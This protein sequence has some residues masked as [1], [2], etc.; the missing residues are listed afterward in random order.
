[1]EEYVPVG[2]NGLAQR[3]FFLHN[4]K[5]GGSYLNDVLRDLYPAERH[6]PNIENDIAGHA[7]NRGDYRSFAGYDIYAGHYGREI[8]DQVRHGHLLISN[9]RNPIDRIVSLYH[10][11]R[12]AVGLSDAQMEEE[13]FFAVKSAKQQSF[14]DFVASTHPLVLAYTSNFHARQLVGSPWDSVEPE[15]DRVLAGVKD[16]D[17]Y[18]VCELPSLSLIEA[19]RV[20]GW[21]GIE[22]KIVNARDTSAGNVVASHR[23][24]S[25]SR[26]VI[27]R[28]NQLDFA[29]YQLAVNMLLDRQN[30]SETAALGEQAR[31]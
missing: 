12:Y 22:H 9:F 1:L 17:W 14:H 5:S 11:F 23:I 25:E 13:R 26:D 24:N 16:L 4:P 19:E 2:G 20:L 31:A 7:A 18:Y 29:A 28:N 27:L 21:H 3:L 6:C 10:Y 8:F 15:I 30:M